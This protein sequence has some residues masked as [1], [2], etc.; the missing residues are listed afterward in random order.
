MSY[1]KNI[2]F[3]CK[4]VIFQNQDYL[5]IKIEDPNIEDK[6]EQITWSY[7]ELKNFWMKKDGKV[8]SL[9]NHL[10]IIF[11]LTGDYDSTINNWTCQIKSVIGF[12]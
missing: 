8:L 3:E 2:K 5:Y 9:G 10:G 4:K 6:D 11:T 1:F 12:P 7:I